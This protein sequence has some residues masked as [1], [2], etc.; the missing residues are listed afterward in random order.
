LERAG[1]LL[2]FSASPVAPA[3][4][5]NGSPVLLR[6]VHLLRECPLADCLEI[7]FGGVLV[8]NPHQIGPSE[9]L[10]SAPHQDDGLVDVTISSKETG[11]SFTA[12]N[13]FR[14]GGPLS[15]ADF[16]RV[17]FPM[18]FL[19]AGAHGSEWT[20]RIFVRSDAPLSVDTEP[21]TWVDLNPP[22]PPIRQAFPPGGRTQFHEI[23]SES[24]RFFYVPRGLESFFSYSAHVLDLSRSSTNLG[25]EIPVVRAEDTANEIRL[26]DV[27][28]DA[29]FRAKLRIYDWDTIPREVTVTVIRAVDAEPFTFRTRLD[30]MVVTCPRAPCLQP[31]P[32]FASIDL[33]AIPEIAAG[34]RGDVIL[35]SDTKDARLWAFVSVTNN[36]TQQVTVHTP[37][38]VRER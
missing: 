33:S 17:L 22:H 23:S 9:L 25:T 16:D 20:T 11:A 38:H 6:G 8:Q 15:E 31:T 1:P 24:G 10:V 19:G 18:T 5:L 36:V 30:A 26:V 7:T 4:G 2:Y 3:A 32:A 35:T 28:L 34:G 13:A 12:T 29:L 27:P 37:Q 14:Y 21:Q